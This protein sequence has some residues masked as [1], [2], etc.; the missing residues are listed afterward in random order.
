M[1]S[2]IINAFIRISVILMG[3]ELLVMASVMCSLVVTRYFFSYSPGWSEEVTR[4]LMVWMVMTGAALLTLFED[5]IVLYWIV[6]KLPAQGRRF[7]RLAV[8]VVICASIT[9]VAV[10][11]WS[12]V[13]QIGR[14]VAPGLQISMFWPVLAIPV[15]LSIMAFVTLLNA[16]AL[17]LGRLEYPALPILPQTTFFDG[18]FRPVEDNDPLEGQSHVA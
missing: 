10:Y 6:Q 8:N 3:I 4:Y 14:S 9:L 7:H 16:L 18:R 5:Q 15:G 12:F 13:G 11:A 1:F 17:I 2:R